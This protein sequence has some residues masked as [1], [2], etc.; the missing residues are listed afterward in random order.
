MSW[1]DVQESHDK[2]NWS[3]HVLDTSDGRFWNVKEGLDW[4]QESDPELYGL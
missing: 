3:G 1:D 4:A 2:S